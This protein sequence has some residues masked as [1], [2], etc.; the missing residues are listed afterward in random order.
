MVGKGPIIL[1]LITPSVDSLNDSKTLDEISKR[2]DP[3]ISFRRSVQ[4][5][6]LMTEDDFK[7]SLKNYY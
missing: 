6:G 5:V 1:E 4:M 3:L 7:A 2:K